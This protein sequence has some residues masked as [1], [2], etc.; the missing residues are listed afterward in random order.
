MRHKWSVFI[1]IAFTKEFC[2]FPR[3]W[4]LIT[5]NKGIKCGGDVQQVCLTAIITFAVYKM[6]SNM[7]LLLSGTPIKKT[8]NDY[9]AGSKL[10]LNRR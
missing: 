2:C 3:S 6:F 9:V 4:V 1:I 5:Y 7:F 10:S 8:Y